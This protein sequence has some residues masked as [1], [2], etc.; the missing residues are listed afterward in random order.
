MK[1]FFIILVLWAEEGGMSQLQD[2]T[3][4]FHNNPARSGD[5]GN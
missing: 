4:H 5:L 3:V 2:T 1:T